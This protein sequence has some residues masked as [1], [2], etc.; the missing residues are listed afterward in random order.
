MKKDYYPEIR[1][2]TNDIEKYKINNYNYPTEVINKI[3]INLKDKYLSSQ[4]IPKPIKN[5]ETGML[6]EVW[7]SS[8]SETFGK[9]SYYADL[10]EKQKKAKIATMLYLAK[11]IKYGKIRAIDSHNKHNMNSPAR[12]YYL[13]HPIIIDDVEYI[14]NIDIRKVPNLNGRFYIHSLHTKKL[15]RMETTKVAN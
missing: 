7:K 3:L 15:E 10:P 4:S 12:Y 6:I 14:V 11:M 5:I 9:K 2:S 1:I 13:K 8:I